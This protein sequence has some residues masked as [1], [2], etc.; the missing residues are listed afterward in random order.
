MDMQVFQLGQT[1]EHTLQAGPG[2]FSSLLIPAGVGLI[3]P[4]VSALVAQSG[5]DRAM[6]QR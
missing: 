1:S 4:M 2:V 6:G 3:Q 5:L